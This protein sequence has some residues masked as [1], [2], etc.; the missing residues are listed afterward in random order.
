MQILSSTRAAPEPAA[1]P[2]QFGARLRSA[3]T[4]FALTLLAGTSAADDTEIFVQAIPPA[5]P[6]VLMIIDTSG[7]MESQI[8]VA[9][10]YD[11][12]TTYQGTCVADRVYYSQQ[13]DNVGVPDCTDLDFRWVNLEA[14]FCKAA[15]DALLNVGYYTD[16]FAQ[17]D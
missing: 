11:P 5:D 15:N 13:G 6:N 1:R 10:D 17:W 7:S 4:A 3:L 12:N 14:F 9:E 16:R 2:P 8:V